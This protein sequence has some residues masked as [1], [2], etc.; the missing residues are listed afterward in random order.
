VRVIGIDPGTV[1]IDLC[2]LDDG[3]VFLDLSIPSAVALSDPAALV[4]RIA[5]EAPLDVVA[6]PSGYGLPLVRG[7]ELSDEAL[8]LAMLT[9]PGDMGGIGKLSTLVRALAA[10][11]LPVVFTPGVVHLSTVPSHRKINRADLGTADKVCAAALAISEQARRRGGAPDEV[12]LILLELGGAFTAAVAVSD[13]QI[14]DGIGGTSGPIGIRSAG[15][16]DG[17]V[18]FLAGEITKSMLFSGG[19]GTVAGAPAGDPDAFANPS[20]PRDRLAWDAWLEGGCKAVAALTMSVPRPAEI[21]LSGRFAGSDRVFE[22]FAE[23]LGTL[24]PVR[25]A[26]GFARVAKAAA[27][28]AALIA[29]GLAGGVN[30][31]LVA[32]LALREA[33][34]SV[35]DHLYVVS[36]ADARRRLGL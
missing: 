1:S 10:S 13:G 24:A 17:E 12:S 20:S 27:Q 21:V 22:C 36:P 15:A 18:A 9:A 19:A 11:P 23:R 3:H 31:P 14:V 6:G 32:A 7:H 28:G 26:T 33:G 34:G 30:A 16:L 29:D 5:A 4:A 35:L 8:R 25:R 2:G